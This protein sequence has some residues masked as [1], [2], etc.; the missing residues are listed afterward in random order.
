MPPVLRVETPALDQC[1]PHQL[2]LCK[3][4]CFRSQHATAQSNNSL[5][6]QS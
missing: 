4:P 5:R 1:D 2:T 3:S 6:G